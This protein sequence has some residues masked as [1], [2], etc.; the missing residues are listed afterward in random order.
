MAAVKKKFRTVHRLILPAALGDWTKYQPQPL[1][2]E[3]PWPALEKKITAD[4]ILAWRDYHYLWGQQLVVFFKEALQLAAK[5][6]E[7]LLVPADQA[8]RRSSPAASCVSADIYFPEAGETARLTI[9]AGLAK[10]LA[11]ENLGQGFADL[12]GAQPL[13]DLDLVNL[14]VTLEKIV[15]LLPPVKDR[16]FP[17]A[18]TIGSALKE[19]LPA[20]RPGCLTAGV[21]LDLAGKT[22]GSLEIDYPESLLIKILPALSATAPLGRRRINLS[23]KNLGDLPVPCRVILG[24]ATVTTGELSRLQPG[25]VVLLE[26]SLTKP[27][28]I[29]FGDDIILS[30]GPGLANRHLAIQILLKAANAG[31][32]AQIQT[33]PYLSR[34][35]KEVDLM[36]GK[37]YFS[38]EKKDYLDEDLEEEELEKEKEEEVPEEE[39]KE[40]PEE[41]TEEE[42]KEKKEAEEEIEEDEDE[43]EEYEEDEEDEV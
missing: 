39:E 30:G 43:Y 10:Y 19:N 42:K 25:D 13:T 38:E 26:K 3:A 5:L 11:A 7:V 37:E 24:S 34:E 23:A 12:T 41:E 31:F 20:A 36:K 40:T 29:V 15:R 22:P 21:K 9:S 4:Q 1:P 6:Y 18:A 14:R 27:L 28:D 2:A 8:G 32:P 35:K 17:G 33:G 16:N